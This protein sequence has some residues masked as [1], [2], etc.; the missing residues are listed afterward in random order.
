M[1]KVRN[2]GSMSRRGGIV[3]GCLIVVAILLI[4]GIVGGVF[5]A[6][7]ARDWAASGMSAVAK[8]VVN[9]SDLPAAEK[10]EIIAVFDEVA[11][12]FRNKK[13]TLEELA[14][15]FE[16]PENTPVFGLGMVMQ[17]EGAYLP[18]SGLTDEEKA[19]ASLQLNR[20]EQALAAGQLTFKDATD[21]LDPVTVDEGDG[22]NRLLMPNETNVEQI[23]EVVA[24]AKAAA[25]KVGIPAE[26]DEIDLS[27]EFRRHIEETLGRKIGEAPAGG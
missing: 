27:E 10:P 25:D 4:I 23:R 2:T 6:M 7:N 1:L 17:F 9:E 16:D 3:Q 18:P 22:D 20:V 19:D 12:A 13:V 14:S 26:R 5:I 11:E 8:E 21:I 24:N 15:I